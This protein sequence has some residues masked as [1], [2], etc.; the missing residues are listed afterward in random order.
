[1]DALK[2]STRTIE[3]AR[4]GSGRKKE[5]VIVERLAARISHGLRVAIDRLD[6]NAEAQVDFLLFVECGR[7]QKEPV[8]GKRAL[9]I[10]L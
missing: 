9:E 1:M 3:A 6:A 7:A 10:G 4:R 8:G 2:I 5:R